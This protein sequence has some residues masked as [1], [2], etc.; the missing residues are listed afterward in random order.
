MRTSPSPLDVQRF[1]MIAAAVGFSIFA[2]LAEQEEGVAVAGDQ[3]RTGDEWTSPVLDRSLSIAFLQEPST[4]GKPFLVVGYYDFWNGL[5][6]GYQSTSGKRV[7]LNAVWLPN[8][9]VVASATHL[10]PHTGRVQTF[11]GPRRLGESSNGSAKHDLEF[12]GVDILAYLMD[13]RKRVPGP[14]ADAVNEFIDGEGGQAFFEAVPVLFA[15]LESLETD[16]K[17]SALQAP[18]GAL[19]TALQITTTKYGGFSQAD[20]ILSPAHANSLR[21]ECNGRSCLFRGKNFVIHRNGLFDALS[22]VKSSR[23]KNWSGDAMRSAP[24]SGAMPG[25]SLSPKNGNG[26]CDNPG[27]CFGRCGS[28]CDGQAWMGHV[29]TPAC[30]AHDLCVCMWSHG[31]CLFFD[32]S[33]PP[34]GY[35]PGCGDLFD[36]AAS[37][38]YEIFSLVLE[39]LTSG[40][41]NGEVPEELLNTP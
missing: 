34:N 12:A 32:S 3:K 6:A 23:S 37:Y 10:N 22:K 11:Y 27:L 7:L 5:L 24:G 25:L 36:A 28:G 15:M 19:V 40:I 30:Q 9:S 41:T 21:N 31:A 29:Y 33:G 39:W 16:P 14:R 26:V 18:F 38:V 13:A 2:A 4:S 20:A 35:C 8:G 1:A 17:L